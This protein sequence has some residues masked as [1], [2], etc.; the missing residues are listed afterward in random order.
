[1]DPQTGAILQ[2]V[3][4]RERRSLLL[5]TGDAFPWTTADGEPRLA[6]LRRAI[7]EV[8]D[9]VTALGRFLLKNR[10]TPP[11]GGA[12]PASFTSYNFIALSFLVP[13]LIESERRSVAALEADLA[14]I[15]D[16][17]AKAPVAALL[18]HKKHALA[19]LESLQAPAGAEPPP[20]LAS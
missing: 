5:Y 12:Y 19:A 9:S 1:M 3:L 10:V 4:R 6:A 15:K 20:P 11:P 2:D 18:A 13:R 16:A 17:A 7:R 8:G 14:R